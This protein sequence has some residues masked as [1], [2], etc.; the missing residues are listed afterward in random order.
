M[1]ILVV[2]VF[3]LLIGLYALAAY[4]WHKVNDEQE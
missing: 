1:K 3:V 2:A 4:Y